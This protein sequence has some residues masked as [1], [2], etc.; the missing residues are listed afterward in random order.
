VQL[1]YDANNNGVVDYPYVLTIST[2]SGTTQDAISRALGGGNYYI[3]V[4]PYSTD[5]TN[6]TLTVS[7]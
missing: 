2:N 6:Y 4:Y 5:D 1:I 7:A 3:R